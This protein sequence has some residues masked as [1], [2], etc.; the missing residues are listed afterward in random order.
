MVLL[1]AGDGA[2]LQAPYVQSVAVEID[3]VCGP[4]AFVQPVDIL[5]DDRR[6]ATAALQFSQ[7]GVRGVGR[8]P[9]KGVETNERASPVALSIRFTGDKLIVRH[10]LVPLAVGAF[11]AAVV[12]DPGIR[13]N[14]GARQRHDPLVRRE[15]VAE[16]LRG[17]QV[18][19][20]RR[21]LQLRLHPGQV[22]HARNS[23]RAQAPP[24]ER[25]RRPRPQEQHRDAQRAP[26]DHR[27]PLMQ[28]GLRGA[29]WIKPVY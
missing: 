8:R 10:G 18:R 22:E 27:P 1:A 2:A 15:K 17:V 5:R 23:Q 24:R 4:G 21:S 13:R 14:A 11:D 9:R 7:R 20:L 25:R 12:R 19:G 28:A 3:D 29:T 6:D 16:A 26:E